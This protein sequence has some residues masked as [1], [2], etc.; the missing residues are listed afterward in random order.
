[1]SYNNKFI[2]ITHRLN[3]KGSFSNIINVMSQLFIKSAEKLTSLT[4][5]MKNKSLKIEG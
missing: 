2:I 3:S 4:Q 5:F 1:M